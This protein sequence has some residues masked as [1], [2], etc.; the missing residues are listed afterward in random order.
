M[1]PK[2]YSNSFFRLFH[3]NKPWELFNTYQDFLQ[4]FSDWQPWFACS[5]AT[6]L[7]HLRCDV[8]SMWCGIIASSHHSSRCTLKSTQDGSTHQTS[9]LRW[10]R[11][12]SPIWELTKWPRLPSTFIRYRLG[13]TVTPIRYAHPQRTLQSQWR[14]QGRGRGHHLI[15]PT[16]ASRFCASH[17]Q[18][19]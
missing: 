8:S 14:G 6:R 17:A 11:T 15:T 3:R 5:V 2:I 4:L 13:R 12:F 16:Q 7:W 18:L 1:W 19:L 9:T 10:D